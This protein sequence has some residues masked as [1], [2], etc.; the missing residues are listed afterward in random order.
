MFSTTFFSSRLVNGSAGEL[1]GY[2]KSSSGQVTRLYVHFFDE[3]VGQ[4]RRRNAVETPYLRQLRQTMPDKLPTPID[5]LEFSYSPTKTAFS[6]SVKNTALQFP[7]RLAWAMTMHRV[8]GQTVKKPNK[9]LVSMRNIF[10]PA[11]AYVALSRIE[12]INQLILLDDVFPEQIYSNDEVLDEL[13]KLEKKSKKAGSALSETQVS[14]QVLSLNIRS[15]NKHFED[16]IK[17]RE[18]EHS[19]LV[20]VQQTCLTANSSTDK[21]AVETHSSH[22]NS[23][24]NGKGL[25]VFF[26]DN[27]KHEI[28]VKKDKYQMSK[29]Q[30]TELDVITVYRSTDNSQSGIVTFLKDLNE[31]INPKKKT[32]I[33]GDFNIS[34]PENLLSKEL[35]AWDFKQLVEYPSHIEGNVIDHVYISDKVDRQL[36]VLDQHPVYYSDHD[37]F[38]LN[39]H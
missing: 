11:M 15:L 35:L 14:L 38:K 20:L 19:D 39:L 6:T 2:E 16:L 13:D 8:Q 5:K 1:I 22:F 7:V 25:A 26:K 36:V 34:F 37:L 33:L 29:F 18:F 10:A 23:V 24:G 21:F 9:I 30:S 12:N 4:N 17:E 27:F 3:R 32:A 31:M 28:D